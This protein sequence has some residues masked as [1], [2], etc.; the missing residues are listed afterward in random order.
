MNEKFNGIMLDIETMGVRNNAI[1]LEVAI[2]WLSEG[3][4]VHS[5]EWK[6]NAGWQERQGR[7]MDLDTVLWWST[8]ANND[9]FRKAADN[10]GSTPHITFALDFCNTLKDLYSKGYT[11]LWAKSPTFDY[12]ILRDL[13]QETYKGDEVFPFRQLRD[14][15]TLEAIAELLGFEHGT[16][17]QKPVEPSDGVPHTA[18][19]DAQKQLMECY[20]MMNFLRAIKPIIRE[21]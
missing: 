6:L 14:V 15:R 5:K 11:T 13:I 7:T 10:E 1:V 9:I 2:A 17:G 20:N 12:I 19:Y 21:D 18:L 3:G 8:Q 4:H 16:L